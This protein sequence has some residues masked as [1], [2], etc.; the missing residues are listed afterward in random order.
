MVTTMVESTSS[1]DLSQRS[2]E[3]SAEERFRRIAIWVLFIGVILIC[4][5]VFVTFA[6]YGK[7]DELWIPMA[8]E[9]FAAMV[10]LPMAALASFIVVMVLRSSAGPIEFEAWGLKLKGAAGP[11]VFWVICFMAI[12]V[13]IKMLW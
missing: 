11:I 8:R 2:L 4:V 9:H 12:A 10:G 7:A 6:R 1:A 5:A 13:C 3:G